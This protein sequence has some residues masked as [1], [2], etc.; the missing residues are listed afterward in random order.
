MNDYTIQE[1]SENGLMSEEQA[2]LCDLCAKQLEGEEYVV[3]YKGPSRQPYCDGA[4]FG[5]RCEHSE[6][7]AA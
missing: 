7:I 2:T 3:L 6:P 5:L 1:W 4:R